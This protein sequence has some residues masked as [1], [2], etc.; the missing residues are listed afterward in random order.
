[1][2]QRGVTRTRVIRPLFIG[3]PGSRGGSSWPY[4]RLVYVRPYIAFIYRSV[5]KF[6]S[7][8]RLSS[9]FGGPQLEGHASSAWAIACCTDLNMAP[10]TSVAETVKLG[11]DM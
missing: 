5:P 3:R 1:M 6:L 2:S 10:E 9:P 7:F 8:P 11:H 4:L